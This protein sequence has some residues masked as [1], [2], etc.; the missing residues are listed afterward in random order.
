MRLTLCEAPTREGKGS[1]GKHLHTVIVN[2]LVDD[3][4][5]LAVSCE[6]ERVVIDCPPTC[7]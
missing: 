2:S 5:L 4:T 6:A 1:V 3:E 7:W